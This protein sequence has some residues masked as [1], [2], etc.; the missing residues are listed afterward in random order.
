MNLAEKIG[1]YPTQHGAHCTACGNPWWFDRGALH[2]C[3]TCGHQVAPPAPQRLPEIE[4]LVRENERLR[5]ICD[6]YELE[7]CAQD[8]DARGEGE[9]E[10]ELEEFFGAAGN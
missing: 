8:Q 1:K 4:G 2:E 6:Q 3:T 9:R 7:L 10:R 5:E